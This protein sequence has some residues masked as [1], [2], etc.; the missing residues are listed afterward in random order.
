MPVKLIFDTDMGNDVDDALALALIHSL[1]NRHE[2]EL[3]AV[4]ISKDHPETVP[5]VDAI[6]TFYGRGNIP[7]GIVKGGATPE[8]SR[9]TPVAQAREG[10]D[11]VFPH[12]AKLGAPV[13]D[14][15][16]VL[17]KTLAAH[18]DESIVLVV[19]GF[20][21]N[22]SRLLNSSGDEHSPLPGMDLVRRKVKLLSIMAGAFEPIR[23]KTHLEYNIVNDIPA[24]QFVAEHWPTPVAWSGFE[25]GLAI[26]YPAVSIEQD[27]RYIER[28]PIAESYQ[29]YI[30]TPHER[31][32][33]DLTSVLHAVRPDRD[34]FGASAPGTVFV[35]EDGETIFQPSNDGQHVYL[36]LDDNKTSQIR[37]LFAALVSE[38][39]QGR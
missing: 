38:P 1:Q 20:S 6:N 12:T 10:E 28:H 27:F 31:P 24:A 13:E 11:Y 21:T 17:R 33:W 19:V 34:Y 14:A 3:L 37:E 32:T 18:P 15:V 23:G 8:Q 39:P 36:L 5:Y 9:F 22:L 35:K 2:C 16:A 26:R 7:L 25:I 4:T 29:A 30:P